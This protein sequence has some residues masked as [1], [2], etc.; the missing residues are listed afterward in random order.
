MRCASIKDKVSC[1]VVGVSACGE[2][3]QPSPKKRAQGSQPT[4]PLPPHTTQVALITGASAGIGAATARALAAEG[5]DLIL[6]ARRG[7][8]LAALASELSAA[9]GTRVHT[10][11]VDVRD[12]AALTAVI[13]ALPPAFANVDIL[14]NNA[15]LALGVDA[16]HEVADDDLTTM[17]DT[18]CVALARLSRLLTPRMVARDSGDIVNLSSVAAHYHYAGGAIYCATKAWV[19]AFTDC[20]R[21]D[22]VASNVRVTAISPGAVQGGTEFGKIRFKGDEAAAAKVYEGY[23]ALTADDCADAVVYAVTRPS[24]CAVGE[25]VL[26]ATRQATPT[27]YG[28]RVE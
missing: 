25:V 22:L 2:G 8:R 5:A 27:L 20:L 1:R 10:A 18:N 4:P 28:R 14:V 13:D 9:H 15:G 7:D 19:A 26:W 16:A 12:L 24:N 21:S 3:R 11:V 23:D 17:V 6:L